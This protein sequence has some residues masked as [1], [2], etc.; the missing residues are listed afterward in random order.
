MRAFELAKNG[1]GMTYPNPMV[2]CV[3]VCKDRII[4]EGWHR[5]AGG[6]HAEVNAIHSVKEKHLLSESDVYVSLEPC[7]HFGK[8]PPCS[9]LLI[10]KKVKRV[11]VGGID[12]FDKVKGKG[13]KRLENAGVEVVRLFMP[14]EAFDVNKRFFTYHLLKRPYVFLKFAESADGY[15][16]IARN[17][18]DL[19]SAQVNWISNSYSKQV[20]HKLR[21]N[22]S[23]ILVGK[24][25][26][27]ND[28]PS[29][30]TRLWF[31]DNP[32]RVV[33]D[34][35]L[36]LDS[37]LKI[38]SDGTPTLVLT[39]DLQKANLHLRDF[40]DYA[41][42]DRDR[43]LVNQILNELYRRGVQS[44]IVEGG[45]QVLQQFIDNNLWDELFLFQGQRVFGQGIYSPKFEGENFF[46]RSLNKDKFFKFYPILREA[47]CAYLKTQE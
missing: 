34:K 27:N 1:L 28:N 24:N 12:P 14:A 9:D 19:E 26:I 38:L 3:I 45:A 20:A 31:G 30:T 43:S 42:L 8:T 46:K 29:L 5:E 44:L 6:P 13:I 37:R 36:N 41:R 17:I 21:A 22:E 40:I 47:Y 16:D 39:S 4:G 33:V 10:A 18:Q 7:S 15:M 35:D 2:G 23:A 11:I 32:L 25:T